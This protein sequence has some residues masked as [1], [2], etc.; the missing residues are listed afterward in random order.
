MRAWEEGQTW[1]YSSREVA[2]RQIY[3]LIVVH[4]DLYHSRCGETTQEDEKTR[5]S[6]FQHMLKRW[7]PFF[8]GGCV[9]IC[10][11]IVR[12]SGI[13]FHPIIMHGYTYYVPSQK[14]WLVLKPNLGFLT[15]EVLTG[16]QTHW[17][18]FLYM[19]CSREVCLGNCCL[20]KHVSLGKYQCERTYVMDLMQLFLYILGVNLHGSSPPFVG[21]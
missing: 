14:I 5:E 4:R 18:G 9:N 1:D 20:D 16:P 2:S 12:G 15:F 13:F 19:F 7:Q 8:G 6:L 11:Q 10:A 21:H 3:W 17:L